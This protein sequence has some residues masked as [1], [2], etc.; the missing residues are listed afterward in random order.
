MMILYNDKSVA[1]PYEFSTD[2]DEKNEHQVN[3]LVSNLLE[4]LKT[5]THSEVTTEELR[6]NAHKPEWHQERAE[7]LRLFEEI[8]SFDDSVLT[9]ALQMGSKLSMVEIRAFP[10]PPPKPPDRSSYG[11]FLQSSF[12]ITTQFLPPQ[13]PTVLQR[14]MTLALLPWPFDSRLA[15]VGRGSNGPAVAQQVSNT[16]LKLGTIFANIKIEL[17]FDLISKCLGKSIYGIQRLSSFRMAVTEVKSKKPAPAK[18]Q[19]GGGGGGKKKEVKKETGLVVVNSEM[20]EYYDISGCYILRPWAMSIWEI[21]KMNALMRRR[22][23]AFFD[24]EIKKMEIKNYYFPVFVSPSVL[25]KEKDH[26]EGYGTEGFFISSLSSPSV[27]LAPVQPPIMVRRRG[28]PPKTPSSSAK[29]T[30]DKQTTVEEEHVRIDLR[31]SNE[32]TL[33]DIDNLSPKKVEVLLRNLESLRAR[34]SSKLLVEEKVDE[35]MAG[36]GDGAISGAKSGAN[37]SKGTDVAKL[38]ASDA[39]AVGDSDH[40]LALVKGTYLNIQR[41]GG[42]K[43]LNMCTQAADFLDIVQ[44]SLVT[45]WFIGHRI[46]DFGNLHFAHGR[47]LDL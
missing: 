8:C 32:E 40:S 12:T 47:G 1:P 5:H 15:V 21:M 20:I 44:Q 7:E 31:L 35:G 22:E 45:V 46:P 24:P 37:S 38:D 4:D 3:A 28:R 41:A 23:M 2:V 18:N 36:I 33:A 16:P 25:E 17:R 10:T 9:F 34:I 30:P 6:D 29:K 26:I 43:F 11:V 39:G 13:A 19:Y 14:Y 27:L 42:F